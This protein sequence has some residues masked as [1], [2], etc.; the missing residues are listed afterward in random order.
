MKISND[1]K[2]VIPIILIAT[3]I[4]TVIL[5]EQFPDAHI[6]I[7]SYLGFNVAVLIAILGFFLTRK[8]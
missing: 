8:F 1:P 6:I 2:K 4:F 3:L 5:W 7:L